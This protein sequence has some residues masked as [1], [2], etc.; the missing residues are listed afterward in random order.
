MESDKDKITIEDS[1]GTEVEVNY[2][3]EEI[4]TLTS[5]SA[6]AVRAL[7]C[8][9]KIVGISEFMKGDQFWEDLDDRT[10]VG[11]FFNPNYEEIASLNPD[12]VIAYSDYEEDL[13]DKLDKFD[14]T[15]VRLDFY[16][17]DQIEEEI[18]ILGKILDAEDNAE[19]LLDFYEES[20]EE[21]IELTNEIGEEDVKN[22]YIE[23]FEEYTTAATN[24]SN[25]HQMLELINSR[26]IAEDLDKTHPEVSPEWVVDENPEVM[27]KIIRCSDTLGYTVNTTEKV[28]N[29]YNTIME[30][31]GLSLTT[32]LEEDEVHLLSQDVVSA[33][34]Y[35]IG[36]S[37]MAESVY[38]EIYDELDPDELHKTYLTE[39]HDLEYK[40]EWSYQT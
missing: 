6:E 25:W 1:T 30:R 29:E 24:D 12:L 11:N 26:N 13:E 38:P 15:V 32:A 14:I 40:G 18:E 31:T 10:T 23:Q 28:E 21:I 7:D 8:D 37:L 5:N 19:K 2:P 36:T 16:K 9:D 22:V 20:M 33:M 39:F 3:V 35:P 4:V 17:V 27:I 34:R